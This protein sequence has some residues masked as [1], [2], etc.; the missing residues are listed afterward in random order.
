MA[1]NDA[2]IEAPPEVVWSVLADADSYDEW[3]VGSRTIREADPDWPEPGAVFHHTLGAG[4][5]AV[6]DCTRSLEADEPH[7]LVI[8]AKARPLGAARA[9]FLLAPENGG[10]R[11]TMV[12]DPVGRAAPLRLLPAFH[13]LMRVRN[14]E[15]LRR[16]KRLAERRH[17]VELRDLAEKPRPASARRR[18]TG[19]RPRARSPR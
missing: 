11:I 2:H 18:A 17:L 19:R 6:R 5:L 10:T 13:A 14:A 15:S 16:L 12:E 3:V 7:R 1:R 4:P 9:E 8:E